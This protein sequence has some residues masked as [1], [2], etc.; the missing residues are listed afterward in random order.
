M[1]TSSILPKPKPYPISNPQL[2]NYGPIDAKE[3]K[4]KAYSMLNQS[5]E[6]ELTIIFEKIRIRSSLGYFSLIVENQLTPV[7]KNKLKEMGYRVYEISS[8]CC[9]NGINDKISTMISWEI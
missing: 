8:N 6:Y 3:A 7:N 5:K 2:H 9:T 1:K 4:Q